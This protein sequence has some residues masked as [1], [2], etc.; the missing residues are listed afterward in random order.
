MLCDT[1]CHK[2]IP[3]QTICDINSVPMVLPQSPYEG[4]LITL[5]IC[6]AI[7]VIAC[8]VKS[9]LLNLHKSPIAEPGQQEDAVA[10]IKLKLKGDLIDK[11]IAF[12]E[13]LLAEGANKQEQIAASKMQK[14]ADVYRNTMMELIK[15]LDK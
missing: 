15:N 14:Q 13:K 6:V 10:K 1:L 12:E 11:L 7:I 4:A 3:P 2:M 5:V 9:I 8:I